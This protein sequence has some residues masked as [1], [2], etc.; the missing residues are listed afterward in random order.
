MHQIW[1]PVGE[2]VQNSFPEQIMGVL[3]PQL[4]EAVVEVIPQ[5]RVQ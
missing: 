4:M 5:A 2:R 3:V 1:E